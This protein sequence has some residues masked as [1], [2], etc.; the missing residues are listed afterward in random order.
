M[1]F[2]KKIIANELTKEIELNNKNI[3]KLETYQVSISRWNE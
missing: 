2:F 3:W 1:K